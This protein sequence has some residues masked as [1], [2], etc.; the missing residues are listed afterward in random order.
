[1]FKPVKIPDPNFWANIKPAIVEAMLKNP[2]SQAH[3]GTRESSL[4]EGMLWRTK[5]QTNKTPSSPLA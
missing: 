5:I 3:Q 1:M 2:P 4:E